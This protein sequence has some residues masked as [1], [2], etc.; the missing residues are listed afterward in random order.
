MKGS[1][2]AV[3]AVVAL[4]AAYLYLKKKTAAPTYVSPGSIGAVAHSPD[5][6]TGGALSVLGSS[7]PALTKWFGGTSPS[8]SSISSDANTPLLGNTTLWN[9]VYPTP[10]V[11]PYSYKQQNL[12]TSS[13][14]GTDQLFT[15]SP[16]TGSSGSYTDSNPASY[17]YANVDYGLGG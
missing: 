14:L 4:A 6:T 7:I 12:D 8:P 2:L 5:I 15:P 11:L 9:P 17:D 13:L 1:T 3:V 10:S 16:I